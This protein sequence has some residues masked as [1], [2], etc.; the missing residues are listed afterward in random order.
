MTL[1]RRNTNLD[2]AMEEFFGAPRVSRDINYD[3]LESEGSYTLIFEV[4]GIEEDKIN[5]EVKD[6]ILTL[7][8]KD[9]KK[10][11]DIK[12]LV[13][14]RRDLTA[15]KSFKL[16]EDVDSEK[17]SAQYR[18]GLLTVEVEKREEVKPKK[19]EINS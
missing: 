15:K 4:P 6:R 8:V 11:E 17:V 14:N 9:D 1:V 19:I 2:R 5:L 13:R 7:D 16:P 3:V 10:S 18:N 12:Y